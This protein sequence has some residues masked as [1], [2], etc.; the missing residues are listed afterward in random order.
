MNDPDPAAAYHDLLAAG[1][2]LAADS[3]A[4]LDDG[5]RRHGLFFN[6]RPLCTVL[7]PRF[8]TPAQYRFLHDR[9]KLLLPAFRAAHDRAVVDPMFRRQFR[10]AGWEEELLAI[11][12][13]Y[14]GYAPTSRLDAFFTPDGGFRVTEFNAETPAGAGYSDALYEV[15]A[16]LPVFQEFQRDY[17]VQPLPAQQGVVYA[18]LGA[19]R[20]WKNRTADPPRVAILDWREVPTFG[21]F[22]L[23]ARCLAAIGIEARFVDPREVEYD[24]RTLRAGDFS[25]NLVYKR[26]LLGELV[27]RGG[28]DH[29]VIRAVRDGAACMVNPFRCKVLFKKASLAVLSDERNAALFTPGQR[30]AVAAHV[31]W[32]RVVEERRTTFDG[33]P[34]DLVPFVLANRDRL[35]LKPND[36][37]GGHGIV[38][39]WT[40]DAGEWE[41]GV[42]AALFAPHVVQER[43]PT[44]VEPYPVFRDG[45]LELS[46]RTVDTDPFVAFGAHVHGCLTR[47]STGPLVSVTAGGGSAV[48]TV[49]VEPR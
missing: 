5:L 22:I 20:K 27:E 26:V 38:L 10:L 16:G 9:I 46:D 44:P 18:L 35:V 33:R 30:E 24:G 19:Y 29:P 47:L 21:E 2:S 32:T 45:R 28:L 25:I 48:P 36:D 39:G 37:Y 49:L 41:A 15:F 7:R 17:N 43:V 8:L 40:V 13:G 14:D 1:G 34:I 31:P 23:F 12:P 4:A 11:D 3:Q 6:D 42:R